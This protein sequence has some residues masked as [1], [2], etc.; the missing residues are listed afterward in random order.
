MICLTFSQNM[1]IH[2][3]NKY[4]VPHIYSLM[5]LFSNCSNFRAQ[6]HIMMTIIHNLI[7]SVCGYNCYASCCYTKLLNNF[8]L[9]SFY[10]LN[11]QILEFN[12]TQKQAFYWCHYWHPS[13]PALSV[14][15][16]RWLNE[17]FPT[18]FSFTG[19]L[20]FLKLNIFGVYLEKYLESWISTKPDIIYH[21]GDWSKFSY[22]SFELRHEIRTD[23][24]PKF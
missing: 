4:K 6:V 15:Y 11:M 9:S 10:L 14:E 8:R 20:F 18:V 3:L 19:L 21:Y 17:S 7:T 2:I 22:S 16:F 13:L 12:T 5:C 23:F 1:I 24:L